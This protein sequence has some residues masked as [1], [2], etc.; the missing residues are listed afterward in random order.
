MKSAYL[1]V[2]ISENFTKWF[3]F[4]IEEEDGTKRFFCYKN[5]PFGLNDACRVLTKILRSPLERWRRQGIN[6]YLH[7]DDGL[8]IVK[9]R[10][11]AVCASESIRKDLRKYGL[12]V[13]EDKSN[14]EVQ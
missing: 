7:V 13:L 6:V 10:E 8:G 11:A 12:L 9:G 3:G 5:M 4:G 2:P 1:Q 14:W